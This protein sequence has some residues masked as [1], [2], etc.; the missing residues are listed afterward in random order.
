MEAATFSRT[1]RIAALIVLSA[2]AASCSHLTVTPKPVVSHTASFSGNKQTSGVILADQYGVLVD[3]GW[4]ARYDALLVKYGK[5]LNPPVKTGDRIGV[6]K[7][8]NDYRVSMEVSIR[9][10]EMNQRL[11]NGD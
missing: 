10:A 3:S 5:D 7:V 8:G 4:M 6:T 11:R 9:F 1:I 2:C